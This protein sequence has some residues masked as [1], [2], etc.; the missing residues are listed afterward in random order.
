MPETSKNEAI[1][2]GLKGAGYR[3]ITMRVIPKLFLFHDGQQHSELEFTRPYFDDIT[4]ATLH[5]LMRD[6]ILPA[7]QQHRGMKVYVNASGLS[8]IPRTHTGREPR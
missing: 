2:A 4:V 5:T 1:I 3:E 6:K 8:I 7:I